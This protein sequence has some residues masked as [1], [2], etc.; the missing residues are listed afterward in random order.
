MLVKSV[1]NSFKLVFKNINVLFTLNENDVEKDS[2]PHLFWFQM[3]R[4]LDHGPEVRS[5]PSG[6]KP[7]KGPEYSR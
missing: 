5:F 7:C 3:K 4:K 6:K 2:H 1:K